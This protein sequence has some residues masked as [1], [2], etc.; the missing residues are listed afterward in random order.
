M[1]ADFEVPSCVMI[2]KDK[3]PRLFAIFAIVGVLSGVFLEAT[4]LFVRAEQQSINFRF[5]SRPWLLWQ[6]ESLSRLNPS[7]LWQYHQNHEIPRTPWAWDYTLSWLI[8]NNHPPVKTKVV[9]FN[10]TIEDEPPKE[11]ADTFTW[12]RPLLS[13]PVSRATMADVIDFLARAGARVI[14]LDNDFPQYSPDDARLARAMHDATS[15][16]TSGI[17][18]P[19]LVA[20]T[21][22]RKSSSSLLQLEAPTG[23][24]GLFEALNKLEPGVDVVGKYSGTTGFIM[25]ED[26]VVRRAVLRMPSPAGK[27][28]ESIVLKILQTPELADGAGLD[29]LPDT[30]DVDFSAQPRSELY[31]VRPFSYLLDPEKRQAMISPPPGYEDVQPRHA[32]V[33]VGDD[34]VDTYSTP[35]TNF[36]VNLM[37]GSEILAHTIDTVNR[38]SWP[39]RVQGMGAFIYLVMVTLLSALLTVYWKS[40][41]LRLP[42]AVENGQPLSSLQ[43]GAPHSSGASR[44][45]MLKVQAGILVA[46]TIFLAILLSMEL[47][48]AG[49]LFSFGRV[50]VPV[51]NPA[52]AIT[53]AYIAALVF[54]REDTRIEALKRKLDDAQEKLNLE[55]RRHETELELQA[56]EAR[57]RE[58]VREREQRHEFARRINHDLKAPVSVLNWT[59]S[60][61]KADGLDTKG[62]KEKLD[63]LAKTSDRLAALINELVQSYEPRVKIGEDTAA[64]DSYCDI[65][66]IVKDAIAMQK[67]LAEA[68]KS[69]LSIE[70]AP[71]HVVV[72]VEA[73][74][75]SRV[76]DN[77]IRNALLHNAEG[78][79][80]K[81]SV[82][83]EEQSCQIAVTDDGQG[84]AEDSLKQIFEAGYRVNTGEKRS[85]GGQGLGLNIVKAFVENAGGSIG[86]KSRV[87]EG[88][89]FLVTL[90]R[91]VRNGNE[92]GSAVN[93][94][95][96][97]QL[98][99][100]SHASTSSDRD[101]I[102]REPATVSGVG[103]MV[104]DP[105]N[106]EEITKPVRDEKE[107]N[108]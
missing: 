60:K 24:A 78:T 53:L 27:A 9:I 106:Q 44:S 36:G 56:V 95:K 30:I 108:Q 28:N 40:F 34:V 91:V 13:H 99:Q 15:G 90:P 19:V 74:Q 82:N 16:K 64:Q 104:N 50:L 77:L 92:E 20:R 85:D 87:N 72:K 41:Q 71:E 6:P 79:N 45:S 2:T 46:D 3:L 98:C 14:V 70:A 58:M 76:I 17:A 63:R 7:I 61:L 12:M 18:V 83:A 89:T 100:R 37:S 52:F 55:R 25:D 103:S 62:A 42:G 101:Q 86:V 67:S 102:G 48:L 88:T 96:V 33:I 57:Q 21:I 1:R 73:L 105:T 97:L 66:Q 93:S 43:S 23:P 8:E 32:V 81:V 68:R 39:V 54:E 5:Q 31:P 94:E 38:R 65:V 47:L 51:V 69:Q 107:S 80:V 11:A 35:V 10:H 22:N 29:S 75:I 59:L 84:I 4:R 49:V 26:Q